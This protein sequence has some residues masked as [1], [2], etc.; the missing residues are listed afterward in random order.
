MRVSVIPEVFYNGITTDYG[1]TNNQGVKGVKRLKK[2]RLLPE[3]PITFTISDN[4]VK[5]KYDKI[6]NA[7]NEELA[8]MINYA[9]TGGKIK[10]GN[11]TIPPEYVRNQLLIKETNAQ[12]LIAS[13]GGVSSGQLE[14]GFIRKE[15][16]KKLREIVK[17]AVR[18]GLD[19]YIGSLL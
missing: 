6:K 4:P 3:T 15:I 12:D 9:Y 14:N 7:S 16:R 1:K 10:I 2:V 17:D 13:R 18:V 8:R 5:K 19:N 11:K